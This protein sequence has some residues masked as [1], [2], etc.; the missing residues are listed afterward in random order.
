VLDTPADRPPV[1]QPSPSESPKN[2]KLEAWYRAAR[3]RTLT[4]TY[5]PLLL[6]GVLALSEG[7]FDLLRFV[8]ALVGAVSLQIGANLV[9]EYFDYVRGSDTHKEAGQ[10]MIIKNKLL[11]PGEVRNGA[12]GSIAV[13]TVIGLILVALTGPLLLWIGLGGVLVV[14]LYTAG[15]LPLAYIGLGEI[16]VFIF[17]GPLMV[18]GAYYVM[19]RQFEVKPLWIALPIA[20]LTAAIMHANNVRD[21]EADRAAHK[22]TLAVLF[23]RRFARV[24]YLLLIG[25][26]FFAL[27]TLV[28]LGQLPPLTL[29]A[30][31]TL[32]E[33]RILVMLTQL[34]EDV[35]TLHMVQGRTARLLRDFGSAI[36]IGWLATLML[37]A[38]L[39][40]LRL[41]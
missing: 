12:I 19:A 30:L 39:R 21:L 8:L 22:R 37:N 2:A 20:F 13:G 31:A 33:A 27:V 15:P 29:V 17:M 23:G 5:I 14:I 4:A 32:Q 38:L 25:G 10:G 16:A 18:L 28:A 3:P 35:P 34:H 24:E 6:A 26:S 7:V 11:T 40:L 9:N 41:L 36:V 1:A